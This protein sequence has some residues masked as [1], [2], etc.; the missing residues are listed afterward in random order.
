MKVE[1][2]RRK[3]DKKEIKKGKK[4]GRISMWKERRK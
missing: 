4:S 3:E 2:D 1:K